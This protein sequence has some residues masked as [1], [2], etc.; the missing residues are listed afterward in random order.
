MSGPSFLMNHIYFNSAERNPTK[1][2][3]EE[4]T[5]ECPQPQK[6]RAHTHT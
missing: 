5:S 6:T 3:T 2:S 4:E 1:E